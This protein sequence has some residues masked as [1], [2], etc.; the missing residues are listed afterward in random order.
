MSSKRTKNTMRS[1]K[2]K[3]K[4]P[5]S[6][7]MLSL[8]KVNCEKGKILMPNTGKCI[9]KYTNIG[10][11]LFLLSA[12]N[13]KSLEKYNI[14][15]PKDYIISKI[16]GS[17]VVGTVYILCTKT[18]N[19]CSRVI[20]IQDYDPKFKNE[21][22]MHK[23][24]EKLGLSPKFYQAKSH[25]INGIKKT[26]IVSE[27]FD[28]TLNELLKVKQT[29]DVLDN[30]FKFLKE[31]HYL[32]IQNKIIHG[33]THWENMA[34]KLDKSGNIDVFYLNDFGW[35]SKVRKITNE[36]KLIDILQPYRTLWL[37]KNK[38]NRKYLEEKL[39]N[40]ILKET[41]FDPKKYTERQLEHFYFDEL[42]NNYQNKYFTKYN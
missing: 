5:S 10:K 15:V 38:F 6:S 13:R 33:D 11:K 41:G 1:V 19:N 4:S 22:K 20:K 8:S 39:Y 25:S 34:Y 29:K 35:S 18:T 7:P 17:G 24:F 30:I 26:H 16:L 23:L 14:K 42:H 3:I 32:S 12:Q 27:R 9:G 21:V 37:I 36:L 40:H 28:G 31:S 2:R